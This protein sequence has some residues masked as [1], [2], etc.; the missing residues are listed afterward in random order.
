MCCPVAF[1]CFSLLGASTPRQTNYSLNTLWTRYAENGARF[2]DLVPFAHEPKPRAYSGVPTPKN[3]SLTS[4]SSRVLDFAGQEI[5]NTRSS[6]GASPP[7]TIGNTHVSDRPPS[8][9]RTSTHAFSS[10][11]TSGEKLSGIWVLP[12]LGEVFSCWSEPC[13]CS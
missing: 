3:L 7:P 10:T 11:I 8:C 6:P 13:F 4:K 1:P 12:S 5:E 9:P 2:T